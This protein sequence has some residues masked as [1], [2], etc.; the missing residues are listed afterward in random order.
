MMPCN[1][2]DETKQPIAVSMYIIAFLYNIVN[3]LTLVNLSS[4]TLSNKKRDI[5]AAFVQASY[6]LSL[7]IFFCGCNSQV[8]HSFCESFLIRYYLYRGSKE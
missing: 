3:S 5:F 7:S 2:D 6:T 1:K 4:A 8:I